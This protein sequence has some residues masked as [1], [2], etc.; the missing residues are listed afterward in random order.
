MRSEI[1][2]ASSIRGQCEQTRKILFALMWAEDY[3]EVVWSSIGI[4]FYLD[5]AAMALE[6]FLAKLAHDFRHDR[7][8][9]CFL[10]AFVEIAANGHVEIIGNAVDRE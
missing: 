6:T 5:S 4:S 10:N 9:S 7:A 3:S 8:S 2:S 1:R